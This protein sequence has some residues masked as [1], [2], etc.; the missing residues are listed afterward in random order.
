MW[1]K[2]KFW[3]EKK[4]KGSKTLNGPFSLSRTKF[5]WNCKRNS[6]CASIFVQE[7]PRINLTR[8]WHGYNCYFS[9]YAKPIYLPPSF[10]I[11][12]MHSKLFQIW[13]SRLWWASTFHKLSIY[14]LFI[15]FLKYIIAPNIW[16]TK[17][18]HYRHYIAFN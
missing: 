6:S 8:F 7:V 13:T 15:F 17:L 3:K 14:T 9:K 2:R 10:P 11:F 12:K 18:F 1:T 4:E 5:K 16:N